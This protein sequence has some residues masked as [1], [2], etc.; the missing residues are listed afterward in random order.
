MNGLVTTMGNEPVMPH[1][2]IAESSPPFQV[3]RRR[4]LVGRK[5]ACLTQIA[6][7]CHTTKHMAVKPT[8]VHNQNPSFKP[9]ED[10]YWKHSQASWHT[11]FLPNTNHEVKGT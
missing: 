10:S 11:L 7:A 8:A 3:M 5:V 6:M 4:V 9:Q 2:T 1:C